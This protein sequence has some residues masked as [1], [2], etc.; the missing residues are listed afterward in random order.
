MFPQ[1]IVSFKFCPMHVHPRGHASMTNDR[2]NT[3]SLENITWS[4]LGKQ[5]IQAGKVYCSYKIDKRL[6]NLINGS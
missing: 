2:Q 5:N 1:G 4:E 3:N 6:V